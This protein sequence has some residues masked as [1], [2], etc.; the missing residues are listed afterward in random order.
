MSSDNKLSSVPRS[1]EFTCSK[2][3]DVDRT[4]HY[5]WIKTGQVGQHTGTALA[6]IKRC[7]ACNI[8]AA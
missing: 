6:A 7:L 3:A 5:A 2:H 8:L 1:E 4:A